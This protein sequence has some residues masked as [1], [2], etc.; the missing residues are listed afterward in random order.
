MILLD[1]SQKSGSGTVVR[2][3]VALAALLGQELRLT[4]VRAKRRPPGL[5]SQHLRTLE[6][7]S[8][9]TAGRLDGATVGASEFI[10]SPSASPHGGRYVWAI[11]TAGSTTMLAFTVLPL[12]AFADQPSHFEIQGVLFQDFAP[13]AFQFQHV[14]LPLLARMG[15][16]A[17]L[18]ILRPGYVPKGGGLIELTVQPVPGALQPLVLLDQ[19]RV[20]RVWGTALS[21]HLHRRRVSDRMARRCRDGLAAGGLDARID[22]SYDQTA[23]QAGAALAVFAE[24]DS[25]C[26]LGADWAGAPRRPSEAIADEVA[27]MLLEDLRSGATVDRHLADQLVLFAALAE[28]TSEYIIP[29]VTEHVETN[30]WLV[31][32]IL[33]AAVDLSNHRVRIRGIG[34]RRTQ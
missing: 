5:R 15:L 18:R 14:L 4:N 16:R 30:C 10:F 13:S 7:V 29:S 26:I 17:D 34:Y 2:Y 28:G 20:K 31:A 1:G 11:G 25:D 12:A 33:G 21:S 22:A 9:L 24:T 8:H 23:L 6:A 27:R 19:G 32:E 3:A